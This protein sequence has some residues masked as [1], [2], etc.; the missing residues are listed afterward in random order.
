[1]RRRDAKTTHSPLMERNK[2]IETQKT[3]RLKRKLR[4][5]EHVSKAQQKGQVERS[6]DRLNFIVNRECRGFLPLPVI[7]S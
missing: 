2:H 1:M 5:Q 7:D 6:K 4:G 3:K